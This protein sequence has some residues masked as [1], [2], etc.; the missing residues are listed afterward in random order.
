[1]A[2][3]FPVLI[4]HRHS[5]QGCTSNCYFVAKYD[6]LLFNLKGNNNM[7]WNKNTMNSLPLKSI[8]MLLLILRQHFAFKKA[9]RAMNLEEC[10]VKRYPLEK[11]GM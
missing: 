1:M 8:K 7:G 2:L 9:R 4:N 3:T 11:I 10:S 5:L 6:V